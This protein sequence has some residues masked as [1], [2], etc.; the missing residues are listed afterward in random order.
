M[1]AAA[2]FGAASMM[3]SAVQDRLREI[4]TLRAIGIN[5]SVVAV[6]VLA[7]VSLLALIGAGVGVALVALV[8]DGVAFSSSNIT[9]DLHLNVALAL[10][11]IAYAC[12]IGLIGALFPAVQ[13]ARVPISIALR[14]V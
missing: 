4:A 8:L 9:V 14:S 12:V 2:T 7:E 11:G 10:T 5:P 6:S 3:Y 1:G 13:A